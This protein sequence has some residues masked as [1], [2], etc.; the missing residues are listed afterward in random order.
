MLSKAE[1]EIRRKEQERMLAF[2]KNELVLETEPAD[3]RLTRLI[4]DSINNI[5]RTIDNQL[6]GLNQ[7][8]S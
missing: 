6:K 2:Y 7:C 5:I 1:L 3:R 8:T 4:I